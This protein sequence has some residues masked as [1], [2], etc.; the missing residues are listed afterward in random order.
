MTSDLLHLAT[1]TP[2]EEGWVWWLSVVFGTMLL[3]LVLVILRRRFLLPMPHKPSDTT[4]AWKEAGRRV[5]MPKTGPKEPGQE[6]EPR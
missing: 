6:G 4:D 1:L 3:A 2:R 5:A